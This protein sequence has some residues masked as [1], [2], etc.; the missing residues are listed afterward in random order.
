VCPAQRVQAILH[1]AS[2]RALDIDGLGDKLVEQLVERGE[3]RGVA[4]LYGLSEE[5]LTALD[6]MGPKSARN[7]V[8]AIEASKTTTLA[9]FLYALGISDVGEATARS[10]AQHFGSLA[11]IMAADA[12]ALMDVP[13]IGPVIAERVAAFFRDPRNVEVVERLRAAG[14]HWEETAPVETSG[15]PLSGKGFVLTGTLASMSREEAKARLLALGAKVSGSVSGKTDYLVV[16]VDPGTKAVRA[17]E[18]GLSV[19]DEDAFLRMLAEHG[20]A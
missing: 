14:V 7:L 9:R 2:R 5:R 11:A 8:A 6:R 4:D 13:D 10:L 16:G 17:R 20:G 12:E 19:L 15:L 18:L 1:F 3:V